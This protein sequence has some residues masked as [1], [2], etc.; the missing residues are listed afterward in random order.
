MIYWFIMI[1]KIFQK[2]EKLYHNKNL[3]KKLSKNCFKK[4][5]KNIIIGKK[6]LKL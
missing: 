3:Q 4:I 5:A 1:K 6:F 2:I